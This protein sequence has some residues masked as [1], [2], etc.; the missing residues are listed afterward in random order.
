M[1]RGLGGDSAHRFDCASSQN[2]ADRLMKE[3]MRLD[4]EYLL[5]CHDGQQKP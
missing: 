2:T 5:A 3:W 4:D 1:R